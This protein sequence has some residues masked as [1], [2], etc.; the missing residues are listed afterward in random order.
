MKC[1]VCGQKIVLK[2]EKVYQV[3][4]FDAIR[5]PKK[6]MDAVDCVECGCQH[7]LKVRLPVYRGKEVSPDD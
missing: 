1:T 3:C 7:L 2:Q 6:V 4:E 5:S